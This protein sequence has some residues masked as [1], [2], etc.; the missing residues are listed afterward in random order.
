MDTTS[1]RRRW[2]CIGSAL[3]VWHIHLN[4]DRKT[5]KNDSMN[6]SLLGPS[7]KQEEIETKLKQLNA[8]FKVFDEKLIIEKTA[9]FLSE[10]KAI[11]WFQGRMEFGPRALVVD[12]YLQIQDQ[13]NAKGIKL[14][15]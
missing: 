11:G 9:K 10:G 15:D 4:K 12:Q 3:N 1:I 5:N 8:D 7:Y 14:K 6:G 13:K 2:G